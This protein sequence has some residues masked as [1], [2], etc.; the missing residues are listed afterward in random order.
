MA[1]YQRQHQR[2]A[3]SL[4]TPVTVKNKRSLLNVAKVIDLK[5]KCKVRKKRAFTSRVLRV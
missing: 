5:G 4:V 3:K 1:V 2:R